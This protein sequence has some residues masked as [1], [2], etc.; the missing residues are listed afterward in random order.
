MFLDNDNTLQYVGKYSW[1]GV[2]YPASIKQQFTIFGTPNATH[3]QMQ[4]EMFL[5][6]VEV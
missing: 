4:Y 3:S 1:F 2:F 6:S 5:C